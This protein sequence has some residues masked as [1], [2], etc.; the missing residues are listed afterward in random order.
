MLLPKK[1]KFAIVPFEN[2]EEASLI[3]DLNIWGVKDLKETLKIKE[4]LNDNILP[5]RTN[6]KPQA[7][8]EQDY[9]L[10]YDFKNIKV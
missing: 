10:D 3:D 8:I 2:L 6:I 1:R 4:Q 5:P 7:V 9:V